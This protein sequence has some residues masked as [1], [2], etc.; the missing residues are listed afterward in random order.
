MFIR[1]P[2]LN[3]RWFFAACLLVTALEVACAAA[4]PEATSAPAANNSAPVANPTATAMPEA[5]EISRPLTFVTV[6]EPNHI[7]WS[8]G[9]AGGTTEFFRDS[10]NDTLTWKSIGSTE[11]EPRLAE[12]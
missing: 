4:A 5:M 2:F 11:V 8:D 9:N 3:K 6:D 1:T 7:D 12:S 10:F